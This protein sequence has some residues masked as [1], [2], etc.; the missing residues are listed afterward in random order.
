MFQIDQLNR[1]KKIKQDKLS[2]EFKNLVVD[3]ISFN[4]KGFMGPVSIGKIA[5]DLFE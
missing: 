4:I 2:F 3:Y 1:R 5:L